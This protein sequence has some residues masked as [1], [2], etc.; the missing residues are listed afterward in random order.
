MMIDFK[1]PISTTH[2]RIIA[3]EFIG[4][5]D[6]AASNR[7]DSQ[8]E[9]SHRTDVLNNFNTNNAV[10]FKNTENRNFPGC[11]STSITFSP[12][13]EVSLIQFDLTSKQIM[14]LGV[15]GY[16]S[17]PKDIDCFKDSRIT[18]INLLG[19][20]PGREFQ[21]KELDNPKPISAT[22]P[23][24]VNPASGEIMECVFTPFTSEPFTDDPVD[25]IAPTS[26]AE[27][28]VVFPTL[29]CKKS[30]SCIFSPDKAFERF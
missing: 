5:N 9:Q 26:T 23:M 15:V 19:D 16:N 1:M 13:S 27:T 29:I 21:F 7:L 22:N 20:F 8:I 2:Q 6:G 25:F 12:A 10:P 4:I 28:T 18:K 14:T 30:S 17:Y 24:L 3:F 11:P